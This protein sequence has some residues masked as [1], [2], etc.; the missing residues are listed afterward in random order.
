MQTREQ[1]LCAVGNLFNDVCRQLN[2]SFKSFLSKGPGGRKSWHLFITVLMSIIIPFFFNR[3]FLCNRNHDGWLS[4]VYYIFLLHLLLAVQ[5]LFEHCG[6]KNYLYY[7]CNWTRRECT[8]LSAMK[9]ALR[10]FFKTHSSYGNRIYF[11]YTCINYLYNVYITQLKHGHSE[12]VF[13]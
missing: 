10:D 8:A 12:A 11:K 5:H 9:F 13:Y 1:L 2:F 6:G 3:C 4:I 7:N